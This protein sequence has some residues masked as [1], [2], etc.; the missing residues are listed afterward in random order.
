MASGTTFYFLT[1]TSSGAFK[2]VRLPQFHT[3]G[4]NFWVINNSAASALVADY[5]D[6]SW[7]LNAGSKGFWASDGSTWTKLV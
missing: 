5:G 1:G 7:I 4:M 6:D 3:I 2:T